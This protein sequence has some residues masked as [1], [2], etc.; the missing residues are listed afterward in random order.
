MAE[1]AETLWVFGSF[2][3]YIWLSTYIFCIFI[4]VFTVRVEK[5]LCLSP[6]MSLSFFT[7]I[8]T[9]LWWCAVC[10]W[11]WSVAPSY[12]FETYCTGPRQHKSCSINWPSC[13][14]VAPT[15]QVALLVKEKATWWKVFKEADGET[16]TAL[17][18]LGKKAHPTADI[19]SDIEKLVCRV[20]VPN[21]TINSVKELRSW[22]FRKKQAQS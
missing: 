5:N 9:A 6:T 11:Y 18:N 4:L 14:E 12:H 15:S 7:K 10:Y 8:C 2:F 19:L 1:R 13:F 3:S 17:A 22:L 20:Y 21:T 16:I